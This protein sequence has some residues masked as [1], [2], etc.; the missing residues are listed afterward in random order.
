MNTKLL[1][2]VTN[3]TEALMAMDAGADIIDLKDPNVGALGA[4]P[5]EITRDIVLAVNHHALVSATVGEDHPTIAHLNLA[6]EQTA[7][8]GVD[9]VKIAINKSLAESLLNNMNFLEIVDK[10]KTLNLHLVAVLFVEQNLVA[11]QNIATH[12]LPLVK[13]LGFYGVM[14]DTEHKNGKSLIYHLSFDSLKSFMSICA[15]YDFVT[16]LAGSLHLNF[17][18]SLVKLKPNYLGFRGGVC[19]DLNRQSE[20]DKSKILEIRS[21]LLKHNKST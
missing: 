3:A 10:L 12:I 9:I 19:H 6:I 13:E 4:L 14:L 15:E 20:L 2:S 1:I 5:H 17:V 18:E 11:N 16:G 7:N 21:L 8:L